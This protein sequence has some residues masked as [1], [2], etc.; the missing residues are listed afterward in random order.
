MLILTVIPYAC[1]D[2]IAGCSEKGYD[3][4]SISDAK[5]MFMFSSDQELQQYIAEVNS[6]TFHFP[7]PLVDYV[8]FN[9][10]Y[11]Y[12]VVHRNTLSGMSRTARS[13]SK[14]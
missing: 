1:R 5:Q 12:N 14:R 7:C 13:S 4:L 9:T 6:I 8:I 10:D 11:K 2:E 3:Y